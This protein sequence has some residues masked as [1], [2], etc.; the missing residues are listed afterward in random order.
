MD[1]ATFKAITLTSSRYPLAI[2]YS[3]SLM[4]ESLG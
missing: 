2:D 4:A 3:A 1:F